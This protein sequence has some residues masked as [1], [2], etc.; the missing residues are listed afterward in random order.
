LKKILFILSLVLLVFLAAGREFITYYIDTQSEKDTTNRNLP[1]IIVIGLLLAIGYLFWFRKLFPVGWGQQKK[2]G[3]IMIVITF[4]VLGVVITR[5]TMISL[6]VMLP[7]RSKVLYEGVVMQKRIERGR[8]GGA[9]YYFRVVNF[10]GK[11]DR[12]LRVSHNIYNRYSSG[13]RFEK[14]F[15]VGPFGV[16]YLEE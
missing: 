12:E 11:P 3:K 13:E 10:R 15:L 2:V 8:K 1:F 14:Y 6:D 16:R 7:H 5:Q 9:S 4:L